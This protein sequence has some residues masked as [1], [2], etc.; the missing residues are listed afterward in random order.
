MNKAL[1]LERTVKCH[2]VCQSHSQHSS[3]DCFWY[4][5]SEYELRCVDLSNE[6][7]THEVS[8][9][10]WKGVE[11]TF[12]IIQNC[13]YFGPTKTLAINMS[14]YFCVDFENGT[15]KPLK[16]NFWQGMYQILGLEAC[17]GKPCPFYNRLNSYYTKFANPNSC[18]CH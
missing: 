3:K 11:Q 13:Q 14:Q 16:V 8:F 2:K 5:S 18:Y 15:L 17:E 4:F 6:I 12:G 1:K 10:I 9:A 7:K